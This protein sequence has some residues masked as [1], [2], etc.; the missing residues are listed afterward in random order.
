[1]RICWSAWR[2]CMFDT[3]NETARLRDSLK[4]SVPGLLQD[5]KEAIDEDIHP[6]EVWMRR[7]GPLHRCFWCLCPRCKPT[8]IPEHSPYKRPGCVTRCCWRC[9]PSRK[10]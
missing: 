9:C 4:Q 3:K 6:L 8:K 7:Q 5:L 1:M 10:P 2:E